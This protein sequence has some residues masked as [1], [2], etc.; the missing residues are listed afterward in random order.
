MAE[1]FGVPG[2]EKPAWERL[3]GETERAFDAFSRY[4]HMQPRERSL[5]AVANQIGLQSERQLKKWSV[6]FAW[7]DR[8]AAFDGAKSLVVI[9]ARVNA[10]ASVTEGAAES[11][12]E[13]FRQQLIED[14]QALRLVGR[15]LLLIAG[16]S[17]DAILRNVERAKRKAEKAMIT[18]FG[19]VIDTGEEPEELYPTITREVQSLARVAK[20]LI[21]AASEAQAGAVGVTDTIAALSTRGDIAAS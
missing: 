12:L 6:R 16:D 4:L 21:L 1:N 18:E 11:E 8:V 19:E 7:T 9:G 2:G 3:P 5:V 17:V 15:R 14:A 20:E 10:M 13:V